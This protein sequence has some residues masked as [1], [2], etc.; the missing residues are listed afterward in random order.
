[1]INIDLASYDLNGLKELQTS[2]DKEIKSRQQQGLKDARDQILAIAQNLGV[3]VEELLAGSPKKSKL[4]GAKVQAQYRN[5]ADESQTWSGRGRQPRWVA[6]AL[7]GG[8]TL[9]DFRI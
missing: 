4:T 2:I 1:M 8:K 3:S 9:N 6:D 7:A 5:P